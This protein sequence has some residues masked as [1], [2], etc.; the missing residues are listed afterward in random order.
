MV[1]CAHCV[2]CGMRCVD[3]MVGERKDGW[4]DKGMEEEKARGERGKAQEWGRGS[5]LV[6]AK[7]S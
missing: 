4:V 6:L 2:E 3:S 5:R 7:V 1:S